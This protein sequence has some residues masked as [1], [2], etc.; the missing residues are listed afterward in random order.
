[1]K[2]ETLHSISLEMQNDNEERQ[3]KT[4]YKNSRKK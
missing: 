3:K 2:F 4:V 1:M